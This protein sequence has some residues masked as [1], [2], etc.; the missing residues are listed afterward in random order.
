MSIDL[1]SAAWKLPLTGNKKLVLMAL[2][3]FANDD[4][5]CWPCIATIAKKTGASESTVKRLVKELI[6]DGYVKKE[7]QYRDNGSQTSNI[8]IITPVQNEGG[9]QNDAPPPGQNVPPLNHQEEPS[10]KKTSKRS[11]S[12]TKQVI[13]YLNEKSGK[14]FKHTAEATKR[15]IQ[16]RVNEGF[17]LED[18]KRVIDHKCS[19]W[20]GDSKMEQYVRPNTLF[21]TKFE[22]Y[23][24]AAPASSDEG[25][26]QWKW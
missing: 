14:S 3:D 1:M 12:I 7:P 20:I 21:G 15:H 23:L 22:G 17:C 16:A 2:A 25:G 6:S 10:S 11:A 26:Y 24:N 5:K 4:G 8:Y 18:F 9:G 19:E 13:I